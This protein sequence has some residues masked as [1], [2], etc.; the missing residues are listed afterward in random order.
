VRAL[1]VSRRQLGAAALVGVMLIFGGN[2]LVV[3]AESVG[4][5]SGIAALLIATVPLI[6]VLLR[7]A[8]GD[9][10]RLATLA[11]VVIGFAGIAALVASRGG[12][13][14]LRPAGALL[15]LVG[16]VSWSV[17]SFVSQRL[18]LP[19]NPLVT[20]VYE[21]V[22]GALAFGL[23]A[24]VSGEPARLAAHGGTA[25]SWLAL[26]YLT[27][28]GSLVAY[29][30]YAWLLGHA[31]ISL[32]STYAYVNPAVAVALGALVVHERITVP[33]LLSGLV[34][35]LGVALVVSTERPRRPLST[36]TAAEPPVR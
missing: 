36:G 18:P 13:G 14:T 11:G 19:P 15:V 1:R 28:F 16:A 27:L 9:R 12:G 34:I 17:G 25:R 3:F 2:G 7:V 24:A 29:T 20:S 31:P 5:P 35:V 22:A 4:V 6:V 23:V 10:P 8:T 33:I 21:M 32:V 30:S 26:L